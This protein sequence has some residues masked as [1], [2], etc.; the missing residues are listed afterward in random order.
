MSSPNDTVGL[1]DPS[2]GEVRTPIEKLKR[3]ALSVPPSPSSERKLIG[4]SNQSTELGSPNSQGNSHPA[5]ITCLDSPILSRHSGKN[6]D[7]DDIEAI[8]DQ[9]SV[10]RKKK[11]KRKLHFFQKKVEKFVKSDWS[12]LPLGILYGLIFLLITSLI[13]ESE[14]NPETKLSTENI[15]NEVEKSPLSSVFEKNRSVAKADKSTANSF[16]SP[17]F[18][19]SKRTESIVSVVC[20]AAVALMVVLGS[21][22]SLKLKTTFLLMI[23]ALIAGRGRS[24]IMSLGFGI[25]I[26]G[27]AGNI[28]ANVQ[29][30]LGPLFVCMRK[31]RNLLL[32]IRTN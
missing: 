9:E 16:D 29:E 12:G 26:K 17:L 3:H 4:R 19:V 27:P 14:D 23:P 11:R 32:I 10:V 28:E 31:W 2:K 15:T 21:L 30:G 6:T 8:T 7:D 22:L 20:G 1:R 25:M 13:L 18:P 5:I 24:F